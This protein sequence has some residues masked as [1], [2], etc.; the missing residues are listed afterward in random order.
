MGDRSSRMLTSLCSRWL[1]PPLLAIAV[2]VLYMG[3][4]VI[5]VHYGPLRL[6]SV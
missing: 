2:D 5:S 3:M 6:C 4:Y 1:W